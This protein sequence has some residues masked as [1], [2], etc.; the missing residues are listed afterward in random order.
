[1]PIEQQIEYLK[2]LLESNN[3]SIL[4]EYLP[5][6]FSQDIDSQKRIIDLFLEYTSNDIW[7]S[8]ELNGILLNNRELYEYSENKLAEMIQQGVSI[9][10]FNLTV[11]K[12][13][14]TVL[15]ATLN[16]GIY[17]QVL[18]IFS[19]AAYEGVGIELVANLISSDKIEFIPQ[20]LQS[21]A[22]LLNI[23]LNNN[24]YKY[25]DNFKPEWSFSEDSANPFTDD[26][27]SLIIS[28]YK[29]GEIESFPTGMSDNPVALRLTLDSGQYDSLLWFEPSAFNEENMAKLKE[30]LK[31]NKINYIPVYLKGSN[32]L[33]KFVIKEC[34]KDL[35]KEFNIE[36]FTIADVEEIMALLKN[37]SL[38]EIPNCFYDS[39]ENILQSTIVTLLLQNDLSK[40]ITYF[41]ESAFTESSLSLFYQ[42]LKEGKIDKIPL[43]L[44]G[45]SE[46]LEAI[47]SSPRK[48]ILDQLTLSAFTTENVN[49]FIQKADDIEDFMYLR[50]ANAE[51]VLNNEEALN[52]LSKKFNDPGLKGKIASLLS[53]NSKIF[54]SLNLGLLS[55]AFSMLSLSFIERI[56]GFEWIQRSLLR[57][58]KSRPICIQLF[59]KI[60]ET[61]SNSTL[62]I[63][64]L[65]EKIC[66][67]GLE[68]NAYDALLSDI[69]DVN[70]LSEED[71]WMF[72]YVLSK[73]GN[74]FSIQ[75]LNDLRNLREKRTSAFNHANNGNELEQ[76]IILKSSILEKR[77]GVS[78]NEAN[79]ILSRYLPKT[80]TLDDLEKNGIDK[81]IIEALSLMKKVNECKDIEKLKEMLD[82][83][84]DLIDLDVHH[85]L[86]AEERIRAAYA[87]MY[88]KT[89]YKPRA[90][91]LSKD[92][93]LSNVEYNGNKI[94]VYELNDDFAMQIH[95]LGAYSDYE[96]PNNF[97][98]AWDVPIIAMHG[99][100]TSYIRNDEIAV[101]RMRHPVLGFIEFESAGFLLQGNYDLVSSDFNMVNNISSMK[102]GLFLPPNMYIN[103][104]RHNHNETVLERRSLKGDGQFKRQ[105]DYIVYITDSLKDD[106]LDSSFWEETKQ[107]AHD[108][109]VPI[110]VIDREKYLRKEKEKMSK[111]FDRFDKTK[112]PATFSELFIKYMNNVVGN[113]AS[114]IES[115]INVVN[116]DKL[117]DYFIYLIAKM[118][119]NKQFEEA[120]TALNELHSLLKK[121]IADFAVAR[122]GNK[123]D[124]P[125]YLSKKDLLIRLL[126]LAKEHKS[127]KENTELSADALRDKIAELENIK[128]YLT[129]TMTQEVNSSGFSL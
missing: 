116:A 24:I 73:M 2:T 19:C 35:I 31:E 10:L 76:M 104:T 77:Y 61:L 55:S 8:R 82:R 106:K 43:F 121:E 15:N 87:K 12:D 74:P 26:N 14:T 41:K 34:S 100:C 91:D 122:L 96:T 63:T 94:E 49:R 124:K 112:N 48:S 120:I 105:P 113:R 123:R 109:K 128:G 72:G 111:L 28:A 83:V 23:L 17:S 39:P 78:I 97:K 29:R 67:N 79:F 108:F 40:H 88:N 56:S 102:S 64:G 58:N 11:F 69:S 33:L 51:E 125:N 1:M 85:L 110:V 119:D 99:L 70:T 68:S 101:A 7:A 66:I 65:I 21:N 118:M 37:G 98:D 5:Q 30:L 4:E 93:K 53:K 71:I 81:N 117:F 126:S 50:M 129:Q 95:V 20:G 84:P 89:L 6:L 60:V 54:E 57:L 107:A 44:N 3:I 80:V 115:K 27:V 59:A 103:K 25:I 9:L 42:K 86:F 75:S 47:I 38:Q 16:A 46:V 36:A 90:D 114:G 92:D 127:Y 62:D 18:N 13:S 32:E 22:R 45:K 52:L